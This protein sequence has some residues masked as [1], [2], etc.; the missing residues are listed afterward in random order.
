MRPGACE[1]LKNKLKQLATER[2]LSLC[3]VE[4]EKNFDTK[5]YLL[6]ASLAA[7][8][9]EVWIGHLEAEDYGAKPGGTQRK[10]DAKLNSLLDALLSKLPTT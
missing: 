5:N 9:S 3:P 7:V 6:R 4:C 8:E 10:V 2:G 1:F